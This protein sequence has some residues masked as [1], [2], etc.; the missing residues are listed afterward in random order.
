MQVMDIFYL[1]RILK[2]A[3]FLSHL[4]LKNMNK[5]NCFSKQIHKKWINSNVH[6]YMLV[7]ISGKNQVDF[8]K[9]NGKIHL[10][11]LLSIDFFKHKISVFVNRDI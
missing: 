10:N 7:F 3:S 11:K 4:M 2:T 9:E 8:H 1:V 6:N 5:E